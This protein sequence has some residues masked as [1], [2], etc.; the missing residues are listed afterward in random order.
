MWKTR[1][2]PPRNGTE[3]CRPSDVIHSQSDSWAD[4]LPANV[5]AATPGQVHDPLRHRIRRK[6]PDDAGRRHKHSFAVIDSPG[7]SAQRHGMGLLVAPLLSLL[8]GHLAL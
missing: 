5:L 2:L 4:E 3:G 1:N 7:E 6:Q 8:L